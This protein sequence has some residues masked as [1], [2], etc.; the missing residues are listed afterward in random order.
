MILIT[1]GLGYLGS[2]IAEKLI[3]SGLKVRIAS[4]RDKPNIP[5]QLR[6]SEV[7]KIDLKDIQSIDN[8]CIGITCIVHLAA[9]NSSECEINPDEAVIINS[10]GTLKLLQSAVNSG[11]SKFLYFST[12][13]V[14]GA[15]LGGIINEEHSICPSSQYAITHK[16]AESHVNS[17][18]HKL[19]TC[20]FR[21][22]NAI[23]SPLTKNSNCWM[24]IAN[25]LCKKIV[26]DQEL[27]VYANKN[28]IRD[29]IPILD[30]VDSTIFFI[31]QKNKLINSQTINIS[32]GRPATLEN[33]CNLLLDRG[34][35]LFNKNITIDYKNS[36]QNQVTESYSISNKK[37]V[38]FG[39]TFSNKISNE[40]DLMMHNYQK[41]F[42]E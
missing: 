21:L 40:I 25:D 19:S 11:V 26:M 36:D 10:D 39:L 17:F 15:K 13:H 30:I 7:V 28:I 38:D 3:N 31:N 37:A 5:K 23:G 29:F 18:S 32:S 14:Y 6:A 33:L 42:T 22:T 24:L 9:L 34:E 41:W 35:V 20:I 8:A 16:T 4:S 12:F 2:R 27:I 1:G